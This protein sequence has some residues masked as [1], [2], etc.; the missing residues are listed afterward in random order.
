MAYLGMIPPGMLNM[1]AL[2][3]RMNFGKVESVKFSLGAS[4]IVLVQASIALVF[5]DFFMKYPSVIEGL[6]VAGVFVLFSLSVYFYLQ[7]KKTNQTKANKQ[8]NNFFLSGVGMSLLNMLAIPFYIGI[9]IYLASI[10][11][12]TLKQPFIFLF[13][14]G[15]A[16]GAL[17]LFYTYIY[18][19]K[20]ILKKVSF[21]ERNINGILSVLF[22]ILGFLLLIGLLP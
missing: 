13:I 10:D 8:R 22:L 4:L 16:I 20:I 7:T 1:T 14:I 2:K 6:K 9:S 3:I 11:K 18:F 5:A 17:A 19:A 15:T 12:I 21:M